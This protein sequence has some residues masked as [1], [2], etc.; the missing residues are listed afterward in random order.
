LSVLSELCWAGILRVET[1]VQF[2]VAAIREDLHREVPV[3]AS[4]PPPVCTPCEYP[5]Y[6]E[7]P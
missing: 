7:Y 4:S 1:V 6:P 2:A 5:E 3:P